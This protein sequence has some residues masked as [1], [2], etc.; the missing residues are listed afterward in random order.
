MQNETVSCLP[1]YILDT[2][3]YSGLFKSLAYLNFIYYYTKEFSSK[4]LLVGTNNG[5]KTTVEPL[6]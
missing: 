2:T 1:M 3:L 4:M 5:V 6:K